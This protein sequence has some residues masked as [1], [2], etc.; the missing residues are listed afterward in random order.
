MVKKSILGSVSGVV[1]A[2]AAGIVA[3]FFAPWVM[4][5][6]ALTA[7][8]SVVGKKVDQ[9]TQTG[10]GESVARV[11]R[12]TFGGIA[13]RRKL[14]LMS[15]WQIARSERSEFV[16]F[17]GE[18]TM[19]SG[20]KQRDPRLVRLLYLVPGVGVLLGVLIVLVPGVGARVFGGISVLIGVFMIY[21]LKTS[22]LG[23]DIAQAHLLWGLWTTT[24]LFIVLG[25]AGLSKK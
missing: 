13:G 7:P 14:A 18:I 20:Q 1:A 3:M 10:I 8:I 16:R 24:G 19:L 9:I 21:K 11:F 12:Q 6:A 5:D 4:V 22:A 23:D 15:G 2:A 25:A 17:A